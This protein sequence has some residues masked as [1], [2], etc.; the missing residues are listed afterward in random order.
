MSERL[1]AYIEIVAIAAVVA[2]LIAVVI[3]LRQTQSALIAS[4]Y[5]ARAIDAIAQGINLAESDYMLPLLIKTNIVEN[6]D[7]ISD[8]TATERAR[9]EIYLRNRIIDLDNEF[10]QFQNGLLDR[11]YFEGGTTNVIIYWAPRWRAMGMT[12]RRQSFKDFV[13]SLLEEATSRQD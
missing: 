2:S 10:Y 12:E 4:T 3:E 1:R 5:Q 9:L 7:A 6:V 11:E 8:L 13:D